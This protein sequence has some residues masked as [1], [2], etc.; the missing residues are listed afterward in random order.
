MTYRGAM[1]HSHR[2]PSARRSDLPF[3][4]FKLAHHA[5]HKFAFT[6]R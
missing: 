1:L 4:A 6:R 5:D 2:L 3:V